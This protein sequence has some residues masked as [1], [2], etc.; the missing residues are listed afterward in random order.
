M[1]S[2]GGFYWKAPTVLGWRIVLALVER[3]KT[4]S[5]LANE[6]KKPLPR[7]SEAIKNIP[8]NFI[9]SELRKPLELNP[10]LK[11]RVERLKLKFPSLDLAKRL[12]GARIRA[13]VA[14]Q[15]G[16]ST[17][18]SISWATGLSQITIKRA[19]PKLQGILWVFQPKKGVYKIRKEEKELSSFC[20]EVRSLYFQNSGLDAQ[21]DFLGNPTNTSPGIPGII[22]IHGPVVLSKNMQPKTKAFQVT[23]LSAFPK[24]GVPLLSP[25]IECVSQDHPVIK[26]EVLIHAIAL[27]T[28]DNRALGFCM[29]FLLKN[30]LDLKKLLKLATYFHCKKILEKMLYLRKTQL[31]EEDVFSIDYWS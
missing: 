24:Y 4:K 13:L 27:N 31:T 8:N 17:V 6:L 21:L 19:L 20:I 25:Q 23:G 30:K 7:I 16:F 10:S 15:E 9:R 2:K 11:T 5:E 28:E 12:S 22:Q 14:L 1:H 29:L 26:E 18:E 3:A